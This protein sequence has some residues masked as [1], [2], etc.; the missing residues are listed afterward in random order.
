MQAAFLF[1]YSGR[2]WLTQKYS[3]AILG[4]YYG[5]TPYHGWEGDED[6]GQMG[7]WFVMSALGLFEM[8]GGTSAPPM[9]D[10]SSPLFDRI[11]IRLDPRFYTGRQFVIEA[12]SNSAENLYIQSAMLNG[13]PLRVPRIPFSAIVAGGTLVLEMG[14]R[15][16]PQLWN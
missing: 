11:M 15:P 7:A 2:P 8:D 16:N 12:R 3:R 14:P 9:V 4:S 5:A 6:E 10:L 13:T 1:N